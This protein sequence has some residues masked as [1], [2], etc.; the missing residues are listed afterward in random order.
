MESERATTSLGP[1]A[2]ELEQ[3]R[4]RPVDVDERSEQL[5]L[6]QQLTL[7]ARHVDVL[8]YRQYAAVRAVHV[9]WLYRQYGWCSIRG[10]APVWMVK[11]WLQVAGAGGLEVSD[12]R[13][14]EACAISHTQLDSACIET[15]MLRAIAASRM[16]PGV[17]PKCHTSHL[18]QCDEAVRGRQVL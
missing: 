7:G 8:Q 5:L 13:F 14:W 18:T 15:C 12:V 11:A 16:L 6:Q 2:R 4:G 1:G 17:A 10:R 9:T 3:H